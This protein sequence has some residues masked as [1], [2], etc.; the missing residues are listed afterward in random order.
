MVYYYRIHQ[1][2]FFII[3]EFLNRE[4]GDEKT[5]KKRS[6]TVS[7]EFG[8]QLNYLME[9]VAQ[10]APHFIRCVK[11]NPRNVPDEF[12]RST[13]TEQLRYGG[14]LQAVQVSRA[15]YPIR[16]PHDEAYLDYQYLR[17]KNACADLDGPSVTHKER[18][19]RLMTHL[20]EKFHFPK[21]AHSVNSWAVGQTMVFF[22]HE[23]YE[24][25]S[26]ERAAL[27]G[28]KACYIQSRWKGNQQRR[29]HLLLRRCV[30]VIQVCD[31]G[32]DGAC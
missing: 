12:E 28:A 18:I 19:S 6:A 1:L 29:M 13:V 11:P 22:K 5:A 14:V 21:P 15:G 25:L 2:L 7:S 24:V 8:S 10:T 27:R 3:S 16:L 17:S 30:I 23:S 32:T 20:E 26:A 31:A 9:T 4:S